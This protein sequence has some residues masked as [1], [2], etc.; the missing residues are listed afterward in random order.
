MGR[1][2][3]SGREATI[4]DNEVYNLVA[5][6]ATKLRGLAAYGTYAR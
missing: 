1:D 5:A 3:G 6:L 4:V 2:R